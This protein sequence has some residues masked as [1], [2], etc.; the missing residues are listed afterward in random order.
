MT[1]RAHRTANTS[2]LPRAT[3]AVE[4]YFLTLFLFISS[5]APALCAPYG[6]SQ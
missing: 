1:L 6:Y 4:F 5:A 3:F 2:V